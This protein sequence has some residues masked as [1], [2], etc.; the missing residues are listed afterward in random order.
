M[1][2]PPVVN[3]EAINYFDMID[4]ESEP[5][6]EPPLTID[7]SLDKIMACIETPMV[8]PAFPN[9]TQAVERMVRVMTEVASKKVGYHSRH[10]HIL[11]KLESRRKVPRFE[12][13]SD[14]NISE[15]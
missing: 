1:F 8:F 6:T 2:I 14:D 12:T 11:Q 15:C 9:N 5:S 7:L 13:K 4:W 10:R 3:F